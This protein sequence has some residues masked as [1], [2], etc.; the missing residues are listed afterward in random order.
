MCFLYLIF[1]ILV[2]LYFFNHYVATNYIGLIFLKVM[3]DVIAILSY[4]FLY[5]VSI[6]L[7]TVIIDIQKKPMSI[8][9]KK[10]FWF[11]LLVLFIFY[12]SIFPLSDYDNK[13][14][15]FVVVS[16]L[17]KVIVS[18]I[19]SIIISYLIDS[20]KTDN[21]NKIIIS[22]IVILIKM[23]LEFYMVFIFKIYI[24]SIQIKPI[25]VSK[26][27]FAIEKPVPFRI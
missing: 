16:F 13:F 26:Y 1:W 27:L 23:L 5:F 9:Y 8:F 18:S 11:L 10:L 3:T 20:I 21:S 4:I 6:Y 14:F 19:S 12:D 2:N 24:L 15:D 25:S 22:I 17:M 7:F